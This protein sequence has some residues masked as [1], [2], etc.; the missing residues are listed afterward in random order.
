MIDGIGSSG[1]LR[2]EDHAHLQALSGGQAPLSRQD[3][4]G[5]G[6]T[7]APCRGSSSYARRNNPS[8]EQTRVDQLKSEDGSMRPIR[9]PGEE[10]DEWL[11]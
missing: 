8:K 5:V 10:C 11:A 7:S 9:C 1:Q 2:G 4:A 3:R 6:T